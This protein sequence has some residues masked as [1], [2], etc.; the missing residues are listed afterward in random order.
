MRPSLL[1]LLAAVLLLAGCGGGS[2]NAT[3]GPPPPAASNGEASKSANQVLA[4][5]KA[6]A[7]HASSLHLSGHIVA[8]GT[9]ISL[10][11]TAGKQ[12]ATGTMSTH[13]LSFDF[14][15]VGKKLYIKGSDAFYKHFAGSGAAQL[16]HGKWLEGSATS[17]KL[18]ELGGLTSSGA[19][20]GSISSSHGKLVNEGA[21]TYQGQS[22]VA[23]KDATKGG[24]LY[25]AA[26][27]KPYPVAIVGTKKGQVGAI[28]FGNWNAPVSVSAPKNAID[29][30]QFGG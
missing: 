18:A 17:G 5:A 20:F 28:T 1:A 9:P 10:D 8:G 26:T 23:I 14:V 29:I 21:K 12:G 24:I 22:V 6:A 16:L 19:I 11:F 15:R 25:V 3:P 30:S 13:G 7:T 4:D 27:G 2:K